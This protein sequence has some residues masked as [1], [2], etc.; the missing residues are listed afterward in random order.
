MAFHEIPEE[1]PKRFLKVKTVFA[2]IGDRFD[3]VYLSDAPSNLGEGKVDYVF[4]IDGCDAVSLTIGGSL[5]GQLKSAKSKGLLKPGART[6][7]QFAKTVPTNFESPRK[8]FKLAVDPDF[9]G[10]PPKNG[11]NCAFE[12]RAP[13]P[14]AD[15][16]EADPFA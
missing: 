11:P 2:K 9:T 1:P 10:A 4:K 15:S 5:H 7:M 14:A 6:V 16:G 13:A 12:E 8:I 3:G